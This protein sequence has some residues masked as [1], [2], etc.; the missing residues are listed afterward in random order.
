MTLRVMT[1]NLWWRF[2]PWEERQRAIVETVRST[3][4]DVLCL[5]EV[6]A[7][8]GGAGMAEVLCDELGYQAVSSTPIGRSDIGFTNAVLSRWPARLLTDEA[9]PARTGRRAIAE[10]SQQRWRRRGVHG[11]SRRRTSTT[12]ST[13]LVSDSC[14]AVDYS[15]WRRSGAATRRRIS[16]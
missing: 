2:G 10:W 1:W 15:I 11:R 12:V 16:L 14:N 8:A 9:L 7:D 5:Q 4:P 13:I 3:I 6:W